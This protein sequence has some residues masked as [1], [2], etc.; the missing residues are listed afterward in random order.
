MFVAPALIAIFSIV[1]FEIGKKFVENP[2][3]S[4]VC[5]NMGFVG[6]IIAAAYCII[7]LTIIFKWWF[8]GIV[9]AANCIVVYM[10]YNSNKK[11]K[12]KK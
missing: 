3:K 12:N 11:N 4:E 9:V 10:G 6:L 2:K 7:I 1:I 5:S 8:V